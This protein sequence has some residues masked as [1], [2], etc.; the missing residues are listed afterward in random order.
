[1]KSNK[2]RIG[3]YRTGTC[4]ND[5]PCEQCARERL[6][7]HK[8]RIGR[9]IPS[10]AKVNMNNVDI[11]YAIILIIQLE[12]CSFRCT[13][14]LYYWQCVYVHRVTAAQND[15]NEASKWQTSKP[16]RRQSRALLKCIHVLKV[17]FKNCKQ[18]VLPLFCG[19]LGI[20][21]YKKCWTFAMS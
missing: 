4:W 19:L 15:L 3:A 17:K 1:M 13:L 10:Y 16:S 20:Q 12:C 18:I 6:S 9:E 5:I 2:S 14:S 7:T 21:L 11:F 8:H